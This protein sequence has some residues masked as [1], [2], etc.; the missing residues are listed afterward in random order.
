MLEEIQNNVA[1]NVVL[2]AFIMCASLNTIDG[3]ASN[4]STDPICKENLPLPTAQYEKIEDFNGSR[5]VFCDNFYLSKSN[6]KIDSTEFIKNKY[7]FNDN[8]LEKI[9]LFNSFFSSLIALSNRIKD[10]FGDVKPTL[11]TFQ[12]S[13]EL[14]LMVNIKCLQDVDESLEK[15]EQLEN[16]WFDESS[17][18]VNS[19]IFIDLVL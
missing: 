9:K 17:I 11:E 12:N 6:M 14:C 2:G 4:V 18:G 3:F 8:E 19:K 7:T 15:F 1:N 13:G 5:I 10:F 16:I